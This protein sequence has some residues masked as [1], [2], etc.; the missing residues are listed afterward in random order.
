MNK[1]MLFDIDG[2][3]IR[4]K[5]GHPKAFSDA[6]KLV[7]NV[8]AEIDVV[9]CQGMTDQ[10][11][12]I[13]T[14]TKTGLRED[15]IRSKIEHCMEE[16]TNSFMQSI[17]ES[18]I[19][20][21]EGVVNLLQ[22]LNKMD[23]IIGL[24]TGNLEPIARAKL[25]KISINHYFKIGGFGNDGTNRAEL[26]RLAI[27]RAEDNF[28]FKLDNNVF[29]VGDTPLDIKAGKEA[30]VKTIGVATGIYSEEPLK[31]TGADFVLKNLADTK[32]VLGIIL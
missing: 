14:L 24:V 19:K 28:N 15:F 20:P 2:T 22:E 26:V 10:Q 12:I 1:L 27:K 23:V 32:K 5:H 7:Y 9:G 30:T 31:N 3:L 8:N 17:S 11:I 13:K 16:M 29:L 25:E 21:M 4:G 18:E 6:F